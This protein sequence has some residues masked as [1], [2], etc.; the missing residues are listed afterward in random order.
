M[1]STALAGRQSCKYLKQDDRENGQSLTVRMGKVPNI[2]HVSQNIVVSFDGNLGAGEWAS[3]LGLGIVIT[4]R[5]V[6]LAYQN[7]LIHAPKRS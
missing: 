6:F 5:L 7:I 4:I 1:T 3:R 2:F